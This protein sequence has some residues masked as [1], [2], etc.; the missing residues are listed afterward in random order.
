MHRSYFSIVL[1]ASDQ[2]R[3]TT[4]RS[5]LRPGSDCRMAWSNCCLCRLFFLPE[6]SALSEEGSEKEK[7]STLV[8]Q[9]KLPLGQNC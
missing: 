9:R 8:Q 2:E 3:Y 6:Q 7:K 4:A 1:T 5:A